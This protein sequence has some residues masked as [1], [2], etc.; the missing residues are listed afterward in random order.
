MNK[1]AP[2]Q[3]PFPAQVRLSR[4]CRLGLGVQLIAASHAANFLAGV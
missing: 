2:R 4:E 3:A 1:G